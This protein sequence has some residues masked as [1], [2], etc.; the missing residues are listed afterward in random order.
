MVEYFDKNIYDTVTNHS[1]RWILEELDLYNP[2]SGITNNCSESINAKLKRLT[3]WKEREVDNII[4]FLYYMQS[5][6]LADLMKS[7]CGVGE[8]QLARKYKFAFKD[9]ETVILPKRVCHPDKMIEM[10]KGDIQAL[11][12]ERK[13]LDDLQMSENEKSHQSVQEEKEN[14]ETLIKMS[15]NQKQYGAVEKQ[16]H[17]QKSLAMKTIADH[18]ISLVPDMGCFL[19]KGNGCKKYAVTLYPKES[20]QCPSTGR[21]YH[22]LSAMM[23]IGQ[24]PCQD[25]K[26]VNLTQLRK[27]SRARKDKKAGKKSGRKGDLDETLINAAPD[28]LI[29]NKSALDK[30]LSFALNT[31]DKMSLSHSTLHLFQQCFSH[32]RT[33]RL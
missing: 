6:D 28:S 18:G 5:N 3:E 25:K 12:R 15:E 14:T 1:A 2:Y 22:I 17:S 30:D 11:E 23:A 33:M 13:T 7:F 26:P 20:C 8:W 31:H 10:I 21:C 27:N 24:E 4:L 19:V 16:K 9:P 29:V 32:I